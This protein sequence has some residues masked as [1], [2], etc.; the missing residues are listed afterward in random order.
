MAEVKIHPSWLAVLKDEFDKEYF[1]KLTEFV[2]QE[3]T[4]K[5]VYPEGKNIFRAFELCPFD[6]VK[7]VILGQDPY[8]GPKQAN[9]LCFSVGDGI[10]LPPSLQNIYK[11]IQSDI[12]IKMPETGN[13]DNWSRQGML[14]LN[15]TL[16]VQANKPGSHQHQG[17]E[18][19]TDAVIK[20]VSEKKEHIVF[21]LWGKYAQE[22]GKIIDP[23]KHFILKAPHP[24]PFS[25]HSGF[26]GS[27]PF[28]KTNDYLKS[29]GEKPIDWS[30]L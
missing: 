13:L 25:A 18:E 10:P 29:I 15:A 3:Y 2:K 17:W 20:E 11:E 4:S 21:I 14:L 23:Q 5:K 28:S 27:K 8:H 22:K 30:S 16:T 26:F 19:F 24:S 12:G 1:Q 7:V 9:G 6:E